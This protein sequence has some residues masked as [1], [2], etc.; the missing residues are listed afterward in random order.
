MYS[1]I[2]HKPMKN[3]KKDLVFELAEL[4]LKG[5]REELINILEGL[6]AKEI[7][8]NRHASYNKYLNLIE[9]YS[10]GIPSL[11]TSSYTPIDNDLSL[12]VDINDIWLAPSIESKINKFV[13]LHQEYSL[14]RVTNQ[15]NKILLYGP[16]GS[17][18]TTI[19]FY[20]AQRLKK[21]ISYVKITDVISSR[22]GET[23][24]NISD[25][26]THIN[27]AV[28]FIDEF[29][30][31]A[32]NRTDKND[33]GELKRIVNSIIQTLDFHSRD[34]I[35]I[36]ATNLLE[37]IDPAILRRFK[38]KILVDELVDGEKEEF[39]NYLTT[40]TGVKES[41]VRMDL[42]ERKFLIDVLDALRIN[43]IDEIADFFDKTIINNLI[44][45]KKETN[46]NDFVRTLFTEDY[47]K[48]PK[49]LRD[50]DQKV[51]SKLCSIMEDMGYAKIKIAEILG[52]HRNS[53]KNYAK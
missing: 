35:I 51:L 28:I 43:T 22:L 16:P 19:G 8:A 44:E 14:P 10:D 36:V 41:Q 20:I 34:K 42:E 46:L 3:Q 31:F 39:F 18:K 15:F 23:M 6:A 11:A 9:K 21:P 53:Y 49:A 29:D 27:N 5:N 37:A 12:P 50:R 13:K 48:K 4:G 17:G 33:V 25:V 7:G 52:I 38:F 2:V 1:N 47:L 24:H 32:K 30:A 45:K 40:K 26:F